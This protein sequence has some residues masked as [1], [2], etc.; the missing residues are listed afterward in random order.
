MK[1]LLSAVILATAALTMQ[2]Q[3]AT[4][5]IHTNQGKEKIHKEIYGQFAEHLGSS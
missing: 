3:D 5:S 2:A 4:V 1:K